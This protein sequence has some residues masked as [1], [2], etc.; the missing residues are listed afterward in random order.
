MHLLNIFIFWYK[1]KILYHCNMRKVTPY[2]PVWMAIALFFAC[3]KTT[4]TDETI[5]KSCLDFTV[6]DSL[7]HSNTVG[8]DPLLLNRE[9]FYFNKDSQLVKHVIYGA[10]SDSI[11]TSNDSFA[12]ANGNM[13]KSYHALGGNNS[14]APYTTSEY[15]Y[16]GHTLTGSRYF[17]GKTLMVHSTYIVDAQGKITSFTQFADNLTYQYTPTVTYYLVYDSAGNLLR[18]NDHYGNAWYRFKNYDNH[19]NPWYKLPFDFAYNVLDYC[20]RVFSKHNYQLTY[21]Y[22]LSNTY[23]S[24]S[25]SY[26]YN[27][28]AEGKVANFIYTPSNGRVS[29]GPGLSHFVSVNYKCK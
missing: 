15:D 18:A 12:Y 23:D 28:D 13:V 19:P 4:N 7:M 1:L 16:S 26:S 20:P 14:S 2:L 6:A 29:N 10:K 8:N 22:L 3:S 25:K 27:Y 21:T 24:T 5:S 11:V 9:G 17:L